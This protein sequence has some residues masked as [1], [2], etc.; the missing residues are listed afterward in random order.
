L[1]SDGDGDVYGKNRTNSS[2]WSCGG[3]GKGKD[4]DK[5]QKQEK[6]EKQ[7]TQRNQGVQRKLQQSDVKGSGTKVNGTKVG[8]AKVK[9]KA[10]KEPSAKLQREMEKRTYTPI[11]DTFGYRGIRWDKRDQVYRSDIDAGCDKSRSSKTA[12]AKV[13]KKYHY[14]PFLRTRDWGYSRLESRRACMYDLTRLIQRT[15]P[16]PLPPPS[17]RSSQA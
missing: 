14:L 13:K 3:K 15:C 12:G 6:H 7:R 17:A 10:E 1:S 2:D 16:L 8:G 5:Q 9:V 4:K 11:A